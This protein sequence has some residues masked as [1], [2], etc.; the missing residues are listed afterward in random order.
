VDC[1]TSTKLKLP[2]P[3]TREVTSYSTQLPA[4]IE[5]ASA[6]APLVRAGRVFQVMPPEPLSLQLVAVAWTAG[7]LVVALQAWRRS[8][9][10]CTVPERPLTA[11]RRK[12]STSGSL[13]PSAR[14]SVEVP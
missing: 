3:L 9:A 14:R 11:K 12:L 8:L 7:P 2:L 10:L 5:P 13:P 4:A 6:T 1:P